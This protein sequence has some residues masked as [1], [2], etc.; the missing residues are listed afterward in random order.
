MT[1]AAIQFTTEYGH[2][3]ESSGNFVSDGAP[4]QGTRTYAHSLGD[5]LLWLSTFPLYKGATIYSDGHRFMITSHP[6]PHEQPVLWEGE[7]PK[8]THMREVADAQEVSTIYS[9]LKAG[10]LP[11][12]WSSLS[13]E[14]QQPDNI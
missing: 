3:S 7:H 12:K 9:N 11:E 8:A 6:I 2:I 5:A 10:P 13:T 1:I 14:W 4:E